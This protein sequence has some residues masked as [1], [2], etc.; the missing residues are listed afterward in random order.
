M[1]EHLR[2]EATSVVVDVRRGIPVVLHWGARITDI[3]ETW[4][5]PPVPY[6]AIQFV[7]PISVVPMHGDGF[8]GRPGFQAHRRG[9]RHWSPR[10]VYESHSLTDGDDVSTLVCHAVDEIA[11]L[12]IQT[13]I[14]LSND[15]VL[16]VQST[17]ENF[18]DSPLMLDAF[19][20]SLPLPSHA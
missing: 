5:R 10:F 4:S 11:E 6:G 20:I 16:K 15:G 1:I 17:V 14:S 8:M 13:N 3:P 2:S 19:A 12:R 7:E 9:G 18:G